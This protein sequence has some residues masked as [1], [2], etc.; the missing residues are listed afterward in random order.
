MNVLRDAL[1]LEAP[2]TVSGAPLF[3]RRVS[4]PSD[5]GALTGATLAVTAEGLVEPAIDGV[6]VGDAVLSPGWTAYHSRL[7]VI[8][9][10]VTARLVPGGEHELTL[11]AGNGWYCGR[12][13][14]MGARGVYGDRPRVAA[15]LTMTFADGSEVIIRTDESWHAVCS[16]VVAD[17]LYDGQYLDLA[18]ERGA[19]HPVLV[20][21][22]ETGR[23]VAAHGPAIV[24]H[25]SVTPVTVT[26]TPTGTLFDFGQNLV[27]WLRLRVHGP[28]GHRLVLTHAEVLDGGELARR[29]LRSARA[30]DT[31]ILSGGDDEIEPTLTF[32]GFRYAHIEGWAEVTGTVEAVVVGSDLPRTGTFACSDADL[33]RF[34]R[35]VVWSLRGNTV[36]IPTDCPQRDE[37]LGWT[38][39]IAVFAPAA[40]YLFEMTGFLRDWLA[41]LRAEQ[42][43]N[44]GRVPYV[45]PDALPGWAVISGEE[46]ESVAI[47]S[48]AAVWVP[49]AVWEAS[50]ELAVLA[51]SYPSMCAHLDRV[52]SRL[53]PRGVWEGDFQFGDWLDPTAPPENPIQ[54]VSD[55][56]VIATEALHRSILLTARTADALGRGEEAEAWRAEAARL[57]RA[58]A[59][60]YLDADCRILSD[61]PAVY[62]LGIVS[63]ILEG[64]AAQAAGDRLAE[65]VRAAGHR[66][67]A[68]FAG[69][70]Y[71]CDAL[72]RTGHLDDA[73]A[74]LL[75]R[76]EPS[77]LSPLARGATTVWERWDSLRADGT[78]NPGEMTSFNHY[79]LGAVADWMHRTVVGISPAA[80][81][82]ARVRI[83]PRP[84]GVLTWARGSV[85]TP[86]GL[87]AAHWQ[88]DAAGSVRVTYC[89]PDEVEVELGPAATGAQRVDASTFAGIVAADA[90]LV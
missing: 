73:Y 6:A 45:V 16:P 89:A 90:A 28:R 70:P 48:D 24:R 81:G 62:A 34:H 78:V 75:G 1:L 10:D 32:H 23:L 44:D 71:L 85:M 15:L 76:D 36:G 11:L 61:A 35:N 7:R 56:G 3:V 47:W 46:P 12:L 83:D 68:G 2:A 77:W 87:V 65:L 4:V 22:L 31:I 19:E 39:D 57:R 5:R 37:R 21:A 41:D 63:G 60:A 42:Q 14:W 59:D 43:A 8:E 27:G 80:P 18:R 30:E 50:G 74:L 82:Y 72:T 49:W 33:T 58:F 38:G 40:C 9:H 17:D 67:I 69:A 20:S 29:P 51:E 25:E 54:A 88:Q 55:P 86:H 66:V 26:P 79:A 53:S 13:G 64:D 84:G 52:R